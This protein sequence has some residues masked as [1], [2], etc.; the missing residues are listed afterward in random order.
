GG[1]VG[2]AQELRVGGRQA[3]LDEAQEPAREGAVAA[4]PVRQGVEE[5]QLEVGEAL[6]RLTG[7]DGAGYLGQ[8][9]ARQLL[10]LARGEDGERG[11]EGARAL[12]GAGLDEGAEPLEGLL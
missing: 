2:G 11:E 6:A 8:L 1:G 12:V 10:L 4:G 3:L 7:R 9:V 5:R